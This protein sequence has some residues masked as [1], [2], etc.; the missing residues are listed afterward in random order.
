MPEVVQTSAMDCGPA[1]LKS[2]LEGFNISVSYGRLREACQTDVDGTSINTIE[3]IAILLGLNAEQVMLPAD[4]LILPEA[5]ALPAIVVVQR[6]NGL[7]HF[8]VVW[9]QVGKYFTSNGPCN[10]AALG[11]LEKIQERDFH[12]FVCCSMPFL[13]RMGWY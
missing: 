4:H 2:I 1:A 7:T 6:P 9:N 3:D 10:R 11:T 13:A 8:L 5:Q 12:S